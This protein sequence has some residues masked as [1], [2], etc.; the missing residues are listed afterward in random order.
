MVRNDGRRVDFGLWKSI[1]PASLYIL[2][3]L[4]SRNT[5]RKLSRLTGKMNVWKDVEELA[6]NFREFDHADPEKFDFALFGLG[7]FEIF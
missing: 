5:S 3:D 7:V 6:A 4:H 2:L 1:V